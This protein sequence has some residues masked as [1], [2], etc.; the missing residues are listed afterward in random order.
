MIGPATI[1]KG[2]YGVNPGV[3]IGQARIARASDSDNIGYVHP[4]LAAD[5]IAAALRS[6]S[7]SVLAQQEMLIRIAARPCHSVPPHQHVPSS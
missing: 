5:V 3:P 7:A 2:S 4:L 6:M 1:A